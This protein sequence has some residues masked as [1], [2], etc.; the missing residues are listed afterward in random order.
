MTFPLVRPDQVCGN[1]V[2]GRLLG[3]ID[4]DLFHKISAVTSNFKV[5]LNV[6]F[7]FIKSR[8]LPSLY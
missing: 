2:T 3:G 6:S 1:I 7:Y 4:M 8:N 5:I